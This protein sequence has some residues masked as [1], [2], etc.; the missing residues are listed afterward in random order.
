[1]KG[2][3]AN[4]YTMGARRQVYEGVSVRLH[5]EHMFVT[6][7]VERI[8]ARRLR[9]EE[10]HSI[11][12]IAN[13]VGVSISSVS[14]WCRDIELRP[15]HV[16]RL[17]ARDP[18]NGGRRKG[19]RERSRRA[20]AQRV[21]WQE[22]GRILA[23]SGDPLHRAGCMLHW[24]EGSKKR[25]SVEFSNSDA[26][27]L[28]LFARFLRECYRVSDD[29]LTFAVNCFLGNGLSIAEIQQFWLEALHL[30]ESCLRAPSVNRASSA[31]QRKGRV[32]VY[33]TG[34]LTLHSTQVAQSI[35]GAIQE[36]GGFDRPEWL[37]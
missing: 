23:R 26:D 10:G 2:S 16:A 20:R 21:V 36:Y 11:K 6:K 4:R 7:H 8:E 12:E 13:E 29:R 24:A 37:D 19:H 27:M 34:R 1:V 17:V 28:R 3:R 9:A 33:G 32:L 18:R 35:Y 25:C 31:S 14:I 30:P 15:E 22:E 5:H